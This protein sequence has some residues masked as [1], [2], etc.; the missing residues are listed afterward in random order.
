MAAFAADALV[1]LHFAFI[2]F[3]VLGG[4]LLLRWPKVAWLHLPAVA[5][6][7]YVEFSGTICPL[8]PLEN[9]WRAAAGEEGYSGGFIEHHLIPL[10]YPAGLTPAVQAAIGFGVLA[11]N[12][13]FYGLWAWRRRWT[14]RPETERVVE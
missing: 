12:G 3:V 8:T 2:V 5:W 11:V 13:V 10:I 1:V 6:G 7:L 9:R 14:H 4:A